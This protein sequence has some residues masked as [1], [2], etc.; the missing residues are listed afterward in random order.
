MLQKP[1]KVLARRLGQWLLCEFAFSFGVTA[2]NTI[3]EPF[4]P[5]SCG[6]GFRRIESLYHIAIL[7]SYPAMSAGVLKH[8]DI[9][10]IGHQIVFIKQTR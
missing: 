8:T 7:Y 10:Y 5:F 9:H 4:F 1:I 2:Q 3:S 6:S